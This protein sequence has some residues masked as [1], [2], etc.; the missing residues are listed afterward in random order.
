MA[1]SIECVQGDISRQQDLEAVVNAAN[2]Q[3]QP[4]GGVAGALHRVA[5]PK[6]ARAC[7]PLAPIKPGQAVI[8]PGFDLPNQWVIHALGPR[9]DTDRPAE[10]LL[11][12]AYESALELAAEN[13]IRAI[14]FPALSAGIF[15]Y[16]LDEAARI[17][18]GT[19]R[20][21]APQDMRVRFV[22]FDEKTLAAFRKAASAEQ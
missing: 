8:T 21:H 7:R 18:I 14:G 15:G 2:A 13:S 17:A 3:L 12:A 19:V 20:A 1:G 10:K 11:A 5:G 4:G 22:L 6:L 9:Y 16:P